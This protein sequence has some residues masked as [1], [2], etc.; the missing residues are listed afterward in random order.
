[1]RGGQLDNLRWFGVAG[2]SH[3]DMKML[4][5]SATVN[6]LDNKAI[7]RMDMGFYMGMT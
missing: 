7:C 2:E 5:I 6:F 4:F 1:M 3:L